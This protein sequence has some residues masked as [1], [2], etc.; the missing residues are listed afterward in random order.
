MKVLRCVAT[1]VAVTTAGLA[2][3]EVSPMNGFPDVPELR[4][5][6]TY[7]DV[8]ALRQHPR[9]QRGNVII[10]ELNSVG[11]DWNAALEI[12]RILRRTRSTVN[13]RSGN[14][15]L[16]AC[17]MVLAGATRRI[18]SKEARIGIHRP[19]SSSNASM[20]FREAQ[21]RYRTLE[22]NA[23]VY[24]REM[25]VSDELFD[26]MVR[27]PAERIRILARS[28]LERFGLASDDPVEAELHDAGE[29]RKYGLTREEY[30][31]R[32]RLIE[33][34]GA[35][36]PGPN[37]RDEFVLEGLERYERCRESILQTGKWDGN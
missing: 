34:C 15:C 4:G 37:V 31:T 23:R 6:I 20:S 9:I 11:G 1:F 36:Y 19:Y 35:F 21:A 29:A 30:L 14:D 16:S 5:E 8:L 27:V 3:S 32:K 28:E 13:V 10:L 12:G 22:T 17:V 33:S 7:Q 26:S 24:L 25:N 2:A 18:V